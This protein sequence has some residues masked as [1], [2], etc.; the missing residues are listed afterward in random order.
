MNPLSASYNSGLKEKG[1]V[2]LIPNYPPRPKFFATCTCYHNTNLGREP[3]YKQS[4]A[5]LAD[6][7]LQE[8][9]ENN[10]MVTISRVW[11]N[12]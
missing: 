6:F 4:T 8:Q 3:D 10:L 12:G 9:P 1:L 5:R 7:A 11:Y 2:Q